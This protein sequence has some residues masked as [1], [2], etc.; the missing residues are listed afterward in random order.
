MTSFLPGMAKWLSNDRKLIESF[1]QEERAEAVQEMSI[2]DKLPYERTLGLMLGG[3]S[4]A[5]FHLE[6]P[7]KSVLLRA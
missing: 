2:D 1:P 5:R 7:T 4:L 3:G 6:R